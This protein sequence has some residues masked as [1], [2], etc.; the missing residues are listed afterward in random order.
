[1]GIGLVFLLDAILRAL[2]VELPGRSLV[3]RPSVVAQSI[4]LGTI[5]TIGSVMVP[6]RRAARTEPIEALRDAAVEATPYRWP[7]LVLPR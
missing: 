5:I 3:I 2:G 6:A 1:M 7:R 4:L